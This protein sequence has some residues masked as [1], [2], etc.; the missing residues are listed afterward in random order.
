M[1]CGTKCVQVLFFI[2]NFLFFLLGIA[3]L[4]VGIYSRVEND[5]WKDLITTDTIMQ[6]ANLLI[7]AGVIVAFIG[8]FGCF[9]AW[10]RCNWMLII[11]AVIVIVIFCLEIAAGIYAYTK[12]ETIENSLT[13][14]VKKGINTNYGKTDTA[15]VGFTK[16]L[17]WFQQKLKCCGAAGPSDWANSFWYKSGTGNSIN[18]AKVPTSCCVTKSNTCNSGT[19]LTKYSNA[20]FFQNGCVAEGKKFAK[21]NLWLIGGVGVGIAVVQLLGIVFALLLCKAY[22]DDKDGEQTA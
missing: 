8:F 4:G 20:K 5:T 14:Q 3:V 13:A 19:S 7:A 22:K 10:K 17:D 15:S 12:R 11:Y 1:G 18:R 21:D 9:G 6:A 16:G 2:F